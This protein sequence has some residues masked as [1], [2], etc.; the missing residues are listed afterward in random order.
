[1]AGHCLTVQTLG[2]SAAYTVTFQ[3]QASASGGLA[4][5]Q[6]ACND[7]VY[8]PDG[9]PVPGF[10]PSGRRMSL[11]EYLLRET[12]QVHGKIR[13]YTAPD[14]LAFY[15]EDVPPLVLP[16]M[17]FPQVIF[18]ALAVSAL[19]GSQL[20]GFHGGCA[21]EAILAIQCL[22]GHCTRSLASAAQVLAP[23]SRE[24]NVNGKILSLYIDHLVPGIA[25]PGDDNNYGSSAM[26]DVL[27]LQVRYEI[28]ALQR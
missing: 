13:R 24:V 23:C 27:A 17:T 26:Y 16:P 5:A 14:E 1:M 10:S 11:L 19:G 18:L 28:S 22:L 21:H 15:P 6:F 25:R 12:E 3:G 8:R 9:V 20:C 2:Y 7:V 4:C